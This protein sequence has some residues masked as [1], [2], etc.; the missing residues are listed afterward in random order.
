M[1]YLKK[2]SGENAVRGAGFAML[3]VF[4][5]GLAA[6][7]CSSLPFGKKK[8]EAPA[9]GEKEPGTPA[10]KPAAGQT[11]ASGRLKAPGA[12]KAAPS[13]DVL[14]EALIEEADL[15]AIKAG[16][17]KEAGRKD[18][19]APVP[20]SSTS[21]TRVMEENPEQYRVIGTARTPQGSV[22]MLQFGN[23]YPI[24]H[25]GDLME[26]GATVKKIDMYTVTIEAD[27]Q[28]VTLNMRT[29]ERRIPEQ[30]Q[31]TGVAQGKVPEKKFGDMMKN[32]ESLY[33]VYLDEKY[34]EEDGY[35]MFGEEKKKPDDFQGFLK[36][37][38]EGDE[39]SENKPSENK[40][41]SE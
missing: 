32:L 7:S 5:L 25:E 37:Y 35:A 11:P 24:V 30:A 9:A 3:L 29:R 17:E 15:D 12:A 36:K 41:E 18:P 8:E 19:F 26:G 2:Q 21:S 28:E 40:P 6:P 22:A 4:L 23:E 34:G 39:K 20:Y 14:D 27:G 10:A 16:F 31:Q 13:T 33:D 1:R 38:R